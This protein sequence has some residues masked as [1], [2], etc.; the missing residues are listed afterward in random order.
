MNVSFGTK[1]GL[2]LVFALLL[3]VTLT[4]AQDDEPTYVVIDYM[5]VDPEM[6]SEYLKVEKVWKKIHAARIKAGKLE[7]WELSRLISPYGTAHEYNYKTAN[8]YKGDKML[9][10]HF[11]GSMSDLSDILTAEEMKILNKTNAVRD[12]VREEIYIVDQEIFRAGADNKITVDNYM[13]LQEGAS[14]ADHSNYEKNVWFPV[15]KA[16]ID[17]GN[18]GGWA[19][20]NLMMP[21]GA[22]KEYHAIT[23]DFYESLD[24]YMLPWFEKYFAKVHPGKDLGKMSDEMDKIWIRQKV[25]VQ[26][27]VD[28]V[29]N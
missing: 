14:L 22:D 13:Q 21:Q 16:R 9:A 24:Q 23:V 10:D 2:S 8:I 20:L 5:K 26:M 12:L 3:S 25:D 15:H 18:M 28:Y 11:T 6:E 7:Y 17:D 19:N 1:I 29:S 27:R 4:Y